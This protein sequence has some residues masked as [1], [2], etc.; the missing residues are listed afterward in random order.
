VRTVFA[1]LLAK[2]HMRQICIHDL[3]HTYSTL[4][5]QTDAPITYFVVGTASGWAGIASGCSGS[6]RSTRRDTSGSSS[7]KHLVQSLARVALATHDR[8]PSALRCRTPP[9]WP[10]PRFRV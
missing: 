10:S 9:R 2:A 4:L 6:S 8:F 3:R 5:L 7:P 1:R